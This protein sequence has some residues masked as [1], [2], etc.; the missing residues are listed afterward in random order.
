LSGVVA[1]R[2]LFSS[3]AGYGHFHP[4]VPLARALQGAGHEVAFAAREHMRSRV[5]AVGFDFFPAGSERTG[6][7]EYQRVRA[8]LDAMPLSLES[9]L[10]AYPRLFAG[11]GTRMM[12]E[13]LVEVAREWKPDMFI[14]EAGAYGAVIAAEHLGL[15]H[16]TVAVAASLKGMAIFEREVAEQLDPIRWAWGLE[17][18]PG[19]AALNRYLLLT[20]SPPSVSTQD[21]G[22]RG[23]LGD[24]SPTTHYVRADF[25]DATGDERLPDWMEALPA[26]P[27]VYVTLGTEVNTEPE[28]YPRVMRTIIEGLRDMKI[29][30]IVTLGRDK[31]PAEFGP[32]PANVHIERYIPQSLLLRRC[33]LMVMHGGSNS[34]LQ[35]L[36]SGIPMVVVPLIADQFF[37]AHVAH[38]LGLGPVVQREQLAPESIRAAVEEALDNPSYKQNVE[39][40]QAEMHALPGMEYAVRLVER[41]ATESEPLVA[42]GLRGVS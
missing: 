39:R 3:G 19:L 4:L 15:P 30:L 25:F 41:V 34:L 22:W 31:D 40:L 37:N 36:D 38:G 5:E 6:D 42:T 16:A 27:T 13:G 33:E 24:I 29:N 7:P 17:P 18:D 1:R 20:Y 14:R 12:V 26:Q 10:Y 32:Q 28:L 21:I 11:I 9:E 8:E 23:M 2:F 35:A